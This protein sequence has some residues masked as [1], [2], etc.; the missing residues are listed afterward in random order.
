[1]KIKTLTSVLLCAALAS[2]AAT[3]ANNKSVIKHRQAVMAA[4]GGHFG[5]AFSTMRGMEQ[6]DENQIFHADAVARLAKISAKTYPAGSGEGKTKAKAEIWDKPEDF[7]KAMDEFV[8]K[9]DEFAAAAKTK[10][11]K[12]YGAAAKALGGSCKG[13][14]D[15]FKA[16]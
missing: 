16:K 15:D 3:A 12:V 9:A 6:F 7:Q 8:V 14:H 10:D 4:I 5:A 13:C 1:M 11:L 2:T